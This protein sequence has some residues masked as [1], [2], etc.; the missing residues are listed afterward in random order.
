MNFIHVAI[1]P[2]PRFGI[3]RSIAFVQV[4]LSADTNCIPFR[5]SLT[6]VGSAL[7]ATNPLATPKAGRKRKSAV[8]ARRRSNRA[9]LLEGGEQAQEM[10]RVFVDNVS[11]E[12]G[13]IMLHF[14]DEESFSP[15]EILG[16]QLGEADASADVDAGESVAIERA[17]KEKKAKKE[18]RAKRDALV[19]EQM[20][21]VSRLV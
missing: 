11:K 18:M 21:L 7:V 13:S 15:E 6:S 2:A 20:E 9:Q 1:L 3:A 16:H 8:A 5:S 10:D 17:E 12:G 4:P 19:L 14:F